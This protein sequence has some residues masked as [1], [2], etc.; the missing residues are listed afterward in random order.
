MATVSDKSCF[1]LAA[2]L[3]AS[4]FVSACGSLMPIE[5]QTADKEIIGETKESHQ[6]A[7]E[8]DGDVPLPRQAYNA[9]GE[10]IPYLPLEN[11]Y[12]ADTTVIPQEARTKFV[13]ASSL[14]QKGDLKDARTR[15]QALTEKYPSLSGPWVKL[16]T[17][18]EKNEKYDDA[19]KHYKKAVSVNRNNVNAYIALGLVQR[20]QGYFPDV[21]KTY[22]QALD[23]WR[24]FPEA[25]L[26]LAIFYDLYMDKAEE[27]QK[28]YEAYYFLTGQKDEKVRKWLVEVKRRTGIETSFIDIP[29]KKIEGTP[30][31]KSEDTGV[32]AQTA[33]PG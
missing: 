16:G 21:Q 2:M 23:V 18:A 26:N 10:K 20:K 33:S 19:I 1:T 29:P 9:A 11:P 22:R 30:T 27:A 4:A 25:H 15:F 5:K 12:N 6:S 14:L 3:I 28:H 8:P 32:V 13:M 17:I 31:E 7:V 24:D